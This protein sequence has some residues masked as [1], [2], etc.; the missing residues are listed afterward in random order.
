MPLSQTKFQVRFMEDYIIDFTTDSN[1]EVTSL[2]LTSNGE[3]IK[4]SK[5]K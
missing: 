3:E 1:N 4:A 5:K 2:S